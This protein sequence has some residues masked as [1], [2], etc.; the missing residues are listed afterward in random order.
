MNASVWERAL[1]GFGQWLADSERSEAT[2][3]GYLKHCGWLA[4][5]TADP[6]T[7]TSVQ[8]QAWIDAHNWSAGT[9]RKV[10]VSLRCFYAW[11]VAEGECRWAPTAGVATSEPR[12]RGSRRSPVPAVWIEPL[13]AFQQWLQA[14]G[15]TASTI[16]QRRW[17]LSRLAEV[18]AD[19]WEVSVEQ[20]ALWLST[21]DWSAETKR[22]GRASVRSFYR[23]AVLTGRLQRSPAADL[24]AVK[25]GR[26]LPRPTPAAAVLSALDSADDRTRLA[27]MLATFAGLRRA[28]IAGLHW[29]DVRDGEV[30]VH[31]KGGIER[32]VP[33]H[34]DLEAALLAEL[35]RR[36]R[37]GHGTGWSGPHVSPT[38]W[39]FP[40]DLEDKPL[41]PAHVGKL[42]SR[43]LPEGWTTHS[44]RHRFAT[45]A[46]R[47]DRDLRAVQE[48]LGH[49]KPE[50]TAR[51]AA[52]PDGALRS[53]VAGVGLGLR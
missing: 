39:L 3:E 34:E 27:I 6:W 12:K 2:A 20:L 51:Y 26:A 24:D 10:L 5:D 44:L 50:T 23:W 36:Q 16:E 28:E 15:R 46:Y 49:S 25:L 21:P 17:W 18:C 45:A 47:A 30:L 9:R 35:R 4:A 32:V 1:S 7:L 42:I 33:L 40:S 43:C 31:G 41:T 29:R 13:T 53:A 19:P 38:G 52:V 11:A 37:G 48:L 8:L 14:S 22:A